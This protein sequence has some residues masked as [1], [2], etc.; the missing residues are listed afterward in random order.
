MTLNPAVPR[1]PICLAE[2]KEHVNTHEAEIATLKVK[3]LGYAI[4]KIPKLLKPEIT[5]I[6]S[7]DY[8]GDHW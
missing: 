4:E 2:L 1:C 6:S 5:I 3:D 8:P 7:P